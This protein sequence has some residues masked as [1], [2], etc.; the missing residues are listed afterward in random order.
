MLVFAQGIELL[1]FGN[2]G[3]SLTGNHLLP[4]R[5]IRVLAVDQ[6]EKIGGDREGELVS[7]EGDASAFLVTT[8]ES[9]AAEVML[10][11]ERQLD[12]PS[13][14]PPPRVRAWPTAAP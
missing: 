11:L 4:N 1:A 14:R 9:L 5:A 7:G 6:V 10:E 8:S 13:H 2:E 12:F 3:F